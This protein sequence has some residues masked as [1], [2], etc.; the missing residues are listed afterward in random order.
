MRAGAA[1]GR[2]RPPLIRQIGWSRLRAYGI[3]SCTGYGQAGVD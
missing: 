2:Y 3:V 1:C